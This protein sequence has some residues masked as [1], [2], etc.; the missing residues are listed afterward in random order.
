MQTVKESSSETDVLFEIL[1]GCAGRRPFFVL[2]EVIALLPCVGI[3]AKVMSC[4]RNLS[5]IVAFQTLSWP[6]CVHLYCIF[7]IIWLD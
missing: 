4:R 3:R 5:G 7:N 2:G 1:Y 6:Q